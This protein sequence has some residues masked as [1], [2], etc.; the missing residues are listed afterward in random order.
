[1]DWPRLRL[2]AAASLAGA[3]VVGGLVVTPAAQAAITSSRITTPVNPSFFIADEDAGTQTFAISGTA[4]GGNPASDEV[5]V[6]CYWDGSV[7]TV[8]KNVPL[9][10]NGSFS[11]A[12]ANLNQP[13]DLTCRLRAVPAGTAPS[14]LT[15]FSGPVIGVG[16]RDSDKVAVGPNVG[17]VT[18]YQVD[19]QQQ[20]AAF[21]YVSLGN[22]G[23]SDGYLYDSALTQTTTTFYCNAGL[24]LQ[25]SLSTPTRSGIQVD[26]ANAY[27]PFS[28]DLIN[29]SAAGLPALTDRY[30]V[31]R[32]TGN[33]VIHETEPLVKCTDATYPPNPVSCA[34]FVSAGVT[35]KRTIAQDHDGHVSWITDSFA[36]TDHQAHSLDL[37]WD[38]SQHFSGD[39]GDSSQL[40]YEFPGQSSFSTYAVGGT[41]TLPAA[42]GTILIRMRGAAD[43]DMQTGRGAIVYDRPAAQAKFTLV[44]SF[45]SEFTL[46]QTGM[47]AAGGTTQFRFAYVQDYRAAKVASLANSARTRF[48]NRIA[49]SKSGRG[50]GKVTST[51]GGIA[52]GKVC[53]HDFATATSV[54][55]K[56]RAAK[57]SRFSG[58]SGA[59]RGIRPCRITINGSAGVKAK[60]VL[61]HPRR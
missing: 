34:T 57:G 25:D 24:L 52:C 37:L 35:D 55:L 12:K 21:D 43:G 16:E 18:G 10:P 47:V 29:P 4:R 50:K 5:D 28:A 39:S 59:C 38:N 36:S 33:V 41:V 11:I 1:M 26:G 60:F 15:P 20:T 32:K 3:F 58:W 22:C 31:D 44:Q 17:K 46:G 7:V 19:A 49:V 13:L 9:K 42:A 51:P 45:V 40:E 23:L 30:A 14:N 61:S 8:A 48:L 56:A 53:A 54:T 2:A 27:D 6:N